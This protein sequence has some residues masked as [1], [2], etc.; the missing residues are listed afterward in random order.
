[1]N[2]LFKASLNKQ[3]PISVNSNTIQLKHYCFQ[4]KEVVA[5]LYNKCFTEHGRASKIELIETIIICWQS[6]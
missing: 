6:V 2:Y 5:S 3:S 1:M 4:F